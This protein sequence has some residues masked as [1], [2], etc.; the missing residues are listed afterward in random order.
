M[1]V[2]ATASDYFTVFIEEFLQP[3][4]IHVISEVLDVDVG[5][6]LGFGAQL[7]LPFF[8]GFETTHEPAESGDAAMHILLKKP[9]Q[10]RRNQARSRLL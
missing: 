4:V 1:S 6:L 9:R 3:L 7:G 10:R 8:A 5:E 2:A